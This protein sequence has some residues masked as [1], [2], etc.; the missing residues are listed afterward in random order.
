ML[1]LWC[2]L[3]AIALMGPL[4]W[5]R[6]YAMGAALIIIM[7]MMMIIIKRKNKNVNPPDYRSLAICF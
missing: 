7:M 3:A 1:W 6:P 5:E 4:A 2:Q